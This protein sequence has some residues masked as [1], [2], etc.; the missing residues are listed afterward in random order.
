MQTAGYILGRMLLRPYWVHNR[1][2]KKGMT[3]A[4]AAWFG[5]RFPILVRACKTVQ[6]SFSDFGPCMRNGSGFV[7]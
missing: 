3:T 2:T 7:F 5:F 6:V 4:P 1:Y